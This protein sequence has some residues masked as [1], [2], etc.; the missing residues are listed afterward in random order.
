MRSL[1]YR[2]LSDDEDDDPSSLKAMVKNFDEPPFVL[3][4][5]EDEMFPIDEMLAMECRFLRPYMKNREF[6]E[7]NVDISA[8]VLAKT[9]YFIQKHLEIVNTRNNFKDF[10]SEFVKENQ[11]ILVDLIDAAVI[12]HIQSLLDVASKAVVDMLIGKTREEIR[13]ILNL[14]DDLTVEEMSNVYAFK[15]WVFVHDM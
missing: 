9:V 1:S 11:S 5:R 15:T 7:M 14:K 12:L 4:S 13:T 10:Y 6:G 3:V 2:S 8:N